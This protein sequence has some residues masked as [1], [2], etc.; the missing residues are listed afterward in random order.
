MTREKND[1][2]GININ[3]QEHKISQ[4]ADDT[5]FVLD[6]SRISFEECVGTVEKFGNKSG[7]KLNHGKTSVVWLGNAKNSN[8]RFM[9]HLNMEWNPPKFKVLGV[10]F[11]NNVNE[12]VQINYREKFEEVKQLMKLWL[13]RC[14]TPFNR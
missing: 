2:R 8:I 12:C 11:T 5:E 1:I 9:D 7:L 14:I 3:N 6:G 13:K 4:Y 10:W